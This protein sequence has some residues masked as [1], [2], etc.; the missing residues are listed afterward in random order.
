[1]ITRDEAEEVIILRKA[2]V[3]VRTKTKSGKPKKPKKETIDY[4]DTDTTNQMRSNL[5][6]INKLLAE[7]WVDLEV[8]DS[9]LVEINK[10]LE[11]KSDKQPID[12]TRR[13]LK[14]M[15]NNSSFEQ[16]GRF[17]HGWWQEIPSE[18]RKYITINGKWTRELDYAGI[19]IRMMYAMEG[20]E[21]EDSFDPYKLKDYT[22]HRDEVKQALNTIINAKTKDEAIG[23]INNKL[24]LPKDKNANDL[25]KQLEQIHPKIKHYF[26]TGEG[27]KLQ[28][29]D[30]KI[31]EIVML[32][33]LE[34]GIVA[35]PVHDSFIVRRSYMIDLNPIMREA[36]KQ[37][38]KVKGVMDLKELSPG[39]TL[40]N[41]KKKPLVKDQEQF[42]GIKEPFNDKDMWEIINNNKD[43][44]FQQRESEW[45]NKDK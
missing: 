28:Y 5:A 36:F 4:K 2:G 26:G 14:R 1:M 34:Q 31:A 12:F 21:L 32:E 13:K 10:R 6:R 22:S 39:A 43:N 35:L 38:V 23:S 3:K 30:S 44:K 8:P 29:L 17:Y 19:H 16:G 37:V 41:Q 15:F 18:Y 27:I 9:T 11:R 45:N 24:T 33:L 40:I 20:E 42:P 7:T 25:Y